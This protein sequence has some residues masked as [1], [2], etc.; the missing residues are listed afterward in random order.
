MAWLRRLANALRPGRAERDIAREVSFHI[1]ERADEYRAAGLG[2]QDALRQARRRFGNPTLQ[3]ERT[4]DADVA[5]WAEAVAR[6]LRYAVRTLS[7]TPGFTLTVVLTLA[8]GIGANSAVFSALDTVLLRPLSFPDADRLVLLSQRQPE[9]AETYIA[10][11]R[12]AEWDR[13]AGAFQAISGYYREDVSDTSGELPERVRRA[14]VAPRFFEVWGVGP[15]IGRPFTPDEHRMGGPPAVIVSDRYWRGRLGGDPAVLTRS[16]RI[17]RNAFPIAGVMPATFRFPD[18]DVD[19]WFPASVDAPY[20]QS[21]DSTWYLG[22]GRMRP[23]VTVA[24]A[25]E[26]LGTVQARLAAE[27]PDTDR[28]IGVDVTPLKRHAVGGVG[29]SLWLLFGAVTVLLLIACTNIAALLLARGAHRQPEIALRLSLGASRRT[30]AAQLLTETAMLALAGGLLGLTVAAGTSGALRAWAGDLPRIDEVAIDARILL[31]TL[32]T[33][34]TVALLC[35]LLPALRAAAA[36]PLGARDA[37]RSQVSHRQTLQWALVGTQVALSVT[38]LAAAG[39]LVRSVHELSRVEAGFDPAHVLSFRMS[40]SWGE[41]SDQPRLLARIDGTIERLAA[42]PGVEGAATSGWALPGVPEQWEA[43]FELP[44]ARD[45]AERRMIAE[46]RAVSPGYFAVLRIPLIAGDTCRGRPTGGEG[47]DF[48]VNRSFTARY[49]A[50]RPSVVGLPLRDAGGRLPA[51]RIAGVV[52][53]ARER[54][55]DRDPGPT[56][57]WCYS[58]PSP[59][60]YFVVRAQGDPAALGQAIRLA[61]KEAEPLRS[62]YELAPLEAR[63]GDAFQENR[64]RAVVVTLF[65]ATA[66]S[67]SCIGLYGT[68]SYVVSLRR[69]EVG[70]RLALGATRADILRQ[71][72]AQGLRVAGVAAVAGL[73]LAAAGGRA[74]AGMLYGVSPFDPLTL[75]AVGGLALAVAAL[76]VL[77][78]A[79]RAALLPPT[80]ALREP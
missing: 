15:A 53:D 5:G 37:G 64:L 52:G 41:T 36:T 32:V 46:A 62:V 25:R 42:V 68:V 28:E 33:T 63:L 24:Q 18:R 70:L 60:P 19:L 66:L 56:V 49:L 4:R 78:P 71:F 77:L 17:G 23:G 76:A 59:S 54:G 30:V 40:G 79:T 61:M 39:L 58:A 74:L 38:L 16:V 57:Y 50:G 3:A 22:I 72:L 48:M 45:E 26:S 8:L 34:T 35:G 1:A 44:D 31:Y 47:H 75:S 55:L 2:E 6:H 65:A 73:A 27:F 11:V 13:A 80:E 9:T 20:A 43:T 14:I 12:L 7:R 10:P 21:R 51:G 67:L 29:G 69:R